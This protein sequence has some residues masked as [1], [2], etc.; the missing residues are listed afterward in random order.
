M[1]S[2]QA[3]EMTRVAWDPAPGGG[4]CGNRSHTVGEG[5]SQAL[6]NSGGRSETSWAGS[7][8]ET[9]LGRVASLE[10]AQGLAG[11]DRQVRLCLKGQPPSPRP[12]P[13]S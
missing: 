12:P 7:I 13:R 3:Q 5:V 2:T 4:R 9:A 11:P 6:G 8:R 1:G 10:G